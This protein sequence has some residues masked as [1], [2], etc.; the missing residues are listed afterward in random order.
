MLLKIQ[1]TDMISITIHYA[2]SV[3]HV[4]NNSTKSTIWRLISTPMIQKN[5]S[6]VYTQI[7][8]G[9]TRPKQ[10]IINT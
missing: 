1:L 10:S 5:S 6:V 7:A 4:A 3:P 8:Q 9:D 2:I